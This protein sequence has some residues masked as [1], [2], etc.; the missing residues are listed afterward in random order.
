MRT[1]L[2]GAAL[3]PAPQRTGVDTPG[4]VRFPTSAPT[5]PVARQPCYRPWRRRVKAINAGQIGAPGR[6]N[7][8][9]QEVQR[10]STRAS[11][12]ASRQAFGPR[13]FGLPLV[14]GPEAFG[15]QFEG[16]SHMQGIEGAAPKA[17]HVAP[18]E[19]LGD[20]KRQSWHPDLYPQAGCDV[21]GFAARDG[22][23]EYVLLD[24]VRQV[25]HVQ[26]RRQGP[27]AS[28]RSFPRP[29]IRNSF[30]ANRV[31]AERAVCG[32]CGFTTSSLRSVISS[33]A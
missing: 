19:L 9:W 6:P 3:E 29:A 16:R 13:Q 27:F 28:P 31:G 5:G 15:L 24:G 33:M 14:K 4:S 17:G 32:Y 30:L 26:G 23:T 1:Y 2:A 21:V 25:S 11:T 10:L 7:R 12:S 20:L 8:T 22:S 18:R